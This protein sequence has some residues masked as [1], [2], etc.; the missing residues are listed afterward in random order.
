MPL[1]H[2][3]GGRRFFAL[4]MRDLIGS[5]FVISEQRISSL[6]VRLAALQE[7][8]DLGKKGV[9][10]LSFGGVLLWSGHLKG[11]TNRLPGRAQGSPWEPKK[12][13]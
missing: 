5:R 9:G 3:W 11:R 4:L 1:P 12:I 10:Y 8:E 2:F 7:T 13:L 6:R